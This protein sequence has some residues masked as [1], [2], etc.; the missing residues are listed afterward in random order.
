MENIVLEFVKEFGSLGVILWLVWWTQCRVIPGLQRDCRDERKEQRDSH[1]ASMAQIT[2][3][4][5][6][7]T[8]EFEEHRRAVR[9]KG[10]ET[11]G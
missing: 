7:L 1:V 2:E 6:R 4:L 8:S 5:G 9:S 10:K 3:A 11:D